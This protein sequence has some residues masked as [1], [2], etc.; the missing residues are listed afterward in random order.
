[1]AKPRTQDDVLD[2]IEFN[3]N[4]TE[5]QIY[6]LKIAFASL[7]ISGETLERRLILQQLKVLQDNLQ[8]LKVRRMFALEMVH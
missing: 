2:G 6:Q 5:R 8:L 3:I 7:V 4:A 1:M